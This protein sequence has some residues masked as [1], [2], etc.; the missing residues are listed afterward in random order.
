MRSR[1]SRPDGLAG[2]VVCVGGLIDTPCVG[3][4][5][6]TI[7][8][9]AR[10][11]QVGPIHSRIDLSSQCVRKTLLGIVPHCELWVCKHGFY[12]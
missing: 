11:T 6:P 10:L 8:I 12:G 2:R 3:G 7:S 9:K 5:V 1:V 4:P